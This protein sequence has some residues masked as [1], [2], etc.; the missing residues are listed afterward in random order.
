MR[1]CL[2]FAFAQEYTVT[3]AHEHEGRSSMYHTLIHALTA[4]PKLLL[5]NDQLINLMN[6][7]LISA[8]ADR[9]NTSLAPEEPNVARDD[10][11]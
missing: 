4:V 7:Q 8:T 5:N 6:S 9:S 10:M 1:H 3:I 2:R 11:S